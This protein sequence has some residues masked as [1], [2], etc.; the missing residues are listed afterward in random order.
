MSA[1]YRTTPYARGFRWGERKAFALRR[2]GL[3]LLPRPADDDLPGDFDRGFW[4]GYTPRSTA[5]TLTTGE[6]KQ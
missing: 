6:P 3:P 1:G 5:W 2:A 4:D